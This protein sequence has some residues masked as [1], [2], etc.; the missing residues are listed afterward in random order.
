MRPSVR[1]CVVRG[2]TCCA[3]PMRSSQRL[4]VPSLPASQSISG[5][6]ATFPCC[7]RI[8]RYPPFRRGSTS[9]RLGSLCSHSPPI[10]CPALLVFVLSF[11]LSL[12]MTRTHDMNFRSTYE[13]LSMGVVARTRIWLCGGG[14]W[15][16]LVVVACPRTLTLPVQ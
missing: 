4:S 5:L 16:W 3:L 2:D 8:R 7:S 14:G 15:W 1:P 12:S 13:I 9:R 11:C 6:R 10:A